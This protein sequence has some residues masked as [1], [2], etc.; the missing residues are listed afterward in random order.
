M[1]LSEINFV[2]INNFLD[3][4]DWL[5]QFQDET[6]IIP[7][8]PLVVNNQPNILPIQYFIPPDP[9]KD[10]EKYHLLLM[11]FIKKHLTEARLKV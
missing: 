11:I 8:Q 10:F 3:A 7:L 5:N 1:D 6:I 4:Y 9:D 2:K